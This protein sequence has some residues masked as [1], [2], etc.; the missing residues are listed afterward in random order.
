MKAGLFT[1][2]SLL[3]LFGIVF[4]PKSTFAQVREPLKDTLVQDNLGNVEDQF[5]EYFFEALA[6]K[7]IENHEK[8]ITALLQCKK[9]SPQKSIVDFE[10]GKN[11]KALKE[12]GK[13]EASL[14]KVLQERPN[15]KD[16]LSEIYEVYYLTQDYQKAIPVAESLAQHSV[17]Y[18]EDL[19]NLYGLTQQYEKALNAIDAIDERE[20]YSDY[21]EALRNKIFSEAK[22]PELLEAYLKKEIEQFPD[23]E[24]HYLELMHFYSKQDEIEKAYQIAEGLQRRKPNSSA[25]HFALYK[26]YLTAYEDEKAIAS[27]RIV[28]ENTKNETLKKT[29]IQDLV[30]LVKEK[31]EYEPQLIKILE[32]ELA[33]KVQSDE[34]LGEY[35][36]KNDENEAYNHYLNRLK[37]DPNNFDLLKKVI[38]LEIKQQKFETALKRSNSALEFFPTQPFF[39]YYKGVALRNLSKPNLA[40]DSF[41]EGLEYLLEN[42]ELELYFYEG[43]QESYKTLSN[44]VKVKEYQQKIEALKNKNP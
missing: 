44:P 4:I 37:N 41:Q 2:Y 28:L 33:P 25:A 42:K 18:Y 22:D 9:I 38:H 6:Q 15:D 7:G 34:I 13:A 27:M 12:Y 30:Q 43:M 29:I 5:Q 16:V 19:A 31:P 21:R 20:G 26:K 8:A 1:Y 36:V 35:L 39:Y 17:N 23:V 10:L 14:K 3:M 24:E 11:Y 32:D 40:V